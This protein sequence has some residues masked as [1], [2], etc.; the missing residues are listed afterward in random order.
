MILLDDYDIGTC[1]RRVD[2]R[3]MTNELQRGCNQAKK[4][5]LFVLCFFLRKQTLV[6]FTHQRSSLVS[7][8]LKKV[9]KSIMVSSSHALALEEKGTKIHFL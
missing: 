3:R 4:C 9:F 2:E 8:V 5:G 7:K 6:V 1:P